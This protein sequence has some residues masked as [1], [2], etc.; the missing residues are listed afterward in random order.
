VSEIVPD[1]VEA[2][3]GFI[4]RWSDGQREEDKLNL[5]VTSGGTGFAVGDVTPEVCWFTCSGIDERKMRG[6]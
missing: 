6:R 5:I 1:S 3:Q 4:R 2:I